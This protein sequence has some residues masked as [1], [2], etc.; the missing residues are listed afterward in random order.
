MVEALHDKTPFCSD[1]IIHHPTEKVNNN[2][3][4]GYIITDIDNN[5]I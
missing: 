5:E 2:V 3:I 1:S 4:G